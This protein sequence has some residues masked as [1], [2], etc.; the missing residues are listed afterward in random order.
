MLKRILEF[1][2][3]ARWLVMLPLMLASF[4]AFSGFQEL[5]NEPLRGDAW[6]YRE[7]GLSIRETGIML[8]PYEAAASAERG[9]L[10]PAII[11]PLTSGSEAS[12]NKKIRALN[13]LLFVFCAGG[14]YLLAAPFGNLA[15]VG[16]GC[17]WALNPLAVS[18]A[19]QGSIE[20]FYAFCV[21]LALLLFRRWLDTKLYRWAAL[22]GSAFGVSII[23]RS[24]LFLF[25]PA[26]ALLAWYLARPPKRQVVIF[27]LA[28]CL[29]V[30]LWAARNV[31]LFGEFVPLERGRASIILFDSSRGLPGDRG[32]S[33]V[34]DEAQSV[35]PAF[36][37]LGHEDKLLALGEIARRNIYSHPFSFAAGSVKR[38]F[39]M[40]YVYCRQGLWLIPFVLAG[41]YL[42]W[43]RGKPALWVPYAAVIAYGILI[44]SPL[45]VSDRFMLPFFP[46]YFALASAALMA[47]RPYAEDDAAAWSRSYALAAGAIVFLCAAVIFVIAAEWIKT[48][49]GDGRF[50]S[51]PV[52]NSFSDPVRKSAFLVR[53]GMALNR[54]GNKT[55]AAQAF[56]SA[57]TIKPV[58]PEAPLSL[59]VLLI[60]KN[61]FED[62]FAACGRAA[63]AAR[64]DGNAGLL[65]AAESQGAEALRLAREF[66][67]TALPQFPERE[68]A[69]T[70]ITKKRA[71]RVKKP[72]RVSSKKA[73]KTSRRKKA[74]R[75]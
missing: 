34:F 63:D 13:A 40:A 6:E 72:A 41:L 42:L 27:L 69:A 47:A 71:P 4:A 61:K 28:A 38:A 25:P 45:S 22:A 10:Y 48:K 75:R 5:R 20:M 18:Y 11:A 29:P 58:N 44:Y 31:R 55:A 8:S 3:N 23:C 39:G 30:A 35:Y 64:I 66:P 46:F 2:Q 24:V 52:E 68:K 17:L 59:C 50:L 51:V 32:L 62:A 56:E 53:R 67:R 14:V 43:R 49:S 54:M 15:G 7:M 73:R 60:E 36:N 16:A 65:A 57:E 1:L 21:L 37:G 74:A 26:A 33:E 19:A 9:I 12:S 70:V